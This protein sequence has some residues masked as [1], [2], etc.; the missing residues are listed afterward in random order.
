[1]SR[2]YAE[3]QDARGRKV[4]ELKDEGPAGML[5]LF[6]VLGIAPLFFFGWQAWPLAVADVLIFG[7]LAAWYRYAPPE[8]MRVTIDP[9]SRTVSIGSGGKGRTFA[10]GDVLRAQL[11][12][13][14]LASTPQHPGGP[15]R[16]A[17]RVDL[18]LRS[19]EVVPLM[20]GFKT[21]DVEDCHRLVAGVN[22]ALASH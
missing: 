4:F 20:R 16:E 1:M 7:S 8:G 10:L 15:R 13:E 21:F 17:H 19:G 12:S 18:V 11:N 9:E 14:Y 6:A 2:S 22:R 3:S 5:L